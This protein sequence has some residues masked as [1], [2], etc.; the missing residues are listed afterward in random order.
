[1]AILTTNVTYGGKTPTDGLSSSLIFKPVL[2]TPAFTSL[3]YDVREDIQSSEPMYKLVPSDKVTKKATTCGWNPSGKIADI[4]DDTIDVVKLKIE[5]EQCAMDFDGT[6]LQTVKKRGYDRE[7]L[8]GTEFETILNDIA[9]PIIY[10]D[11]NRIISLADTASA[12]PNYSQ[13]DGKWAKIYAGVAAG[14]IFKA[15]ELPD[16]GDLAAG[17]ANT[18]LMA[19]FFSAPMELQSLAP[20]QKIIVVTR[21]VYNNYL[22]YLATNSQLE[23]SWNVLQNGQK[24]L[25][26]F[27]VP[28]VAEDIVDTYVAADDLLIPHR[29]YYTA[30]NN[31]TIGT[32]LESDFSY[33]DFWYEKKEQMNLMRVEYKLGVSLG[34][35]ELFSVAY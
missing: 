19:V 27:G 22:Q 20:E 30:I 25:S 16:T 13:L 23:S 8:V 32:D 17:A 3:G 2:E 7:N 18:A 4:I 24:T 5:Q 35:G 14:T 1:M 10:R 21:S 34:W 9:Q 29:I 11:L 33:I 31:I 6:I 12:D 26:F 15:A 28:V